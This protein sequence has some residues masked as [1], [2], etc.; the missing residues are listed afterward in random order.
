VISVAH[1]HA[2]ED[3]FAGRAQQALTV[4]GARPGFLRGTL[5]RSVDDEA[6]WVLITEWRDIGSYRRALGSYD[7]KMTATPVLGAALDVPS[8]FEILA[9][10][11][12]GGRLALHASDREP[13]P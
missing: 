10:L 3:D 12:A 7:V 11:Q 5:S 1:F 9:D 6:D 2:P 8:G 13:S 4:L